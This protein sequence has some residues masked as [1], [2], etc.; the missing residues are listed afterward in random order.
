MGGGRG[1][2]LTCHLDQSCGVRVP[3]SAG[4]QTEQW[5]SGGAVRR[6]SLPVLGG[7][8]GLPCCVPH[9]ATQTT[10]TISK[11]TDPIL[12]LHHHHFTNLIRTSIKILKDTLNL[13]SIS[14]LQFNRVTVELNNRFVMVMCQHVIWFSCYR[15]FK[16]SLWLEIKQVKSLN[17]WNDF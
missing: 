16:Y 10:E 13:E 7:P 2:W 14:W 8:R 17:I 9:R 5:G 6:P 15:S 3:H 12:L 1:G 4:A 11:H